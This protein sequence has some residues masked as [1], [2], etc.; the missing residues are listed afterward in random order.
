MFTI[1]IIKEII[2]WGA[3]AENHTSYLHCTIINL[4]LCEI[5]NIIPTMLERGTRSW[6]TIR[7]IAKVALWAGSSQQGKQRRAS[8]ASNWVTAEY[9]SSP[10]TLYGKSVKM[11]ILRTIKVTVDVYWVCMKILGYKKLILLQKVSFLPEVVL[12]KMCCTDSHRQLLHGFR[13][14][15]TSQRGTLLA[16]CV[17]RV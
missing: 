8:V 17:L 16:S 12:H 1:F 7:V 6:G 11:S 3:S 15:Q 9:R 10:D 14:S 4:Y 13:P 2:S 5:S